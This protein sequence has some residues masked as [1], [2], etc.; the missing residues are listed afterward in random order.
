MGN[1]NTV[2]GLFEGAE[3]R[4]H[5]RLETRKGRTGDEYAG[6]LHFHIGL[7]LDVLPKLGPFDFVLIDGDHNWHTV[8]NE[9]RL[10]E[11]KCNLLLGKP[12][13]PR[14]MSFPVR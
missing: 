10:L 8:L 5:F 7:S 1:T 13:C 9:L 11:R 14:G 3:L 4:A 2:L 6:A 12:A